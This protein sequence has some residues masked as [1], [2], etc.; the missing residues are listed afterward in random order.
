MMGIVVWGWKGNSYFC[1]GDGWVDDMLTSIKMDIKQSA[2]DVFLP[3]F[4]LVKGSVTFQLKEISTGGRMHSV[5]P[6]P[7]QLVP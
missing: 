7:K 1:K 3:Q 4:A 5:S 2:E 6:L